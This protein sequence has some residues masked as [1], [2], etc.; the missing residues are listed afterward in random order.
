[1]DNLVYIWIVNHLFEFCGRITPIMVIFAAAAVAI[2]SLTMA[3]V[4]DEEC[5]EKVPQIKRIS[6][7]LMIWFTTLSFL[8]GIMGSFA[9]NKTEFKMVAAYLIGKEVV[10][11]NRAEKIISII[12]TK[13]DEWIKKVEK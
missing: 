8:C 6:K 12:D 2:F 7:K 3:G 1:M 10:Q 11:S 5:K 13:L 4:F 9:L